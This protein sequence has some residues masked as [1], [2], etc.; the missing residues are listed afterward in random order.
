[1]LRVGINGFGRIGRNFFRAV[2][3]RDDI[4]I[5]AINDLANSDIRIHLLQFDSLRGRLPGSVTLQNNKLMFRDKSIHMFTESSPAAIPW[6][7]ANVDIVLESTGKLMDKSYGHLKSGARQVVISCPAYDIDGVDGMF[8]MGINEDLFDPKIHSVISNA[9][10]TVN[11]FGLMVKVLDDAFG[12]Q[13]G[14]ITN[15]HSVSRQQGTQDA[16]HKDFR[17][18]RA[19]GFNMVPQ[20][21]GATNAFA[22][23][24]PKFAG[25]LLDYTVRVP[26]PIGSMNDMSVVLNHPATVEEVNDAMKQG[27]NSKRLRD[28]LQYVEDPIVSTD[29]ISDKASCI[30]DAGLTQAMGTHI[31]VVG[32]HDN[33]WGYSNR[34][35]DLI[36]YVGEKTKLNA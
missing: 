35:A 27:A 32:W 13:S 26:V 2:M 24:M 8:V 16:D 18:A 10:C 25:K 6:D 31:R 7:E 3:D 9:S 17:M 15:V 29:I 4:E 22:E 11:C 20:H 28:Y 33:E 23:V 5:V 1:M 34:L 36:A 21:P 14:L 12:V 30:F 19:A